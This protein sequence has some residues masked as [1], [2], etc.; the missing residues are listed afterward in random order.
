MYSVCSSELMEDTEDSLLPH[1]HPSAGKK[2]CSVKNL[3]QMN[4]DPGPQ[5]AIHCPHPQND[6]LG[7][8][9]WTVWQPDKLQKAAAG[10]GKEWLPFR[11]G[12]GVFLSLPALVGKAKLDKLKLVLWFR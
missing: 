4:T 11:L 12:K 2:T 1:E 8:S 10:K 5:K 3:S 6:F 9:P 7:S